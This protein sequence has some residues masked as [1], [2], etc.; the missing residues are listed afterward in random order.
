MEN[1][2]AVVG[3]A[4]DALVSAVEVVIRVLT[5]LLVIIVTVNVFARYV[6]QIGLIWA[7]VVTILLFV[8]VV[9]LGSYAA[10]RR[11]AHL[12]ITFVIDRLPHK[13]QKVASAIAT[14]LVSIFL[15]V[16]VWS[17]FDLVKQTFT[18]GRV[19]SMLGISAAWGY[20]AVPVS[21]IL[22][23][24]ETARVVFSGSF[25]LQQQDYVEEQ[26]TE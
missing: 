12:A 15:F 10:Y 13:S 5:G 4:Y 22:F 11:K 3:Q 20:L 14:L 2:R 24:I 1:V 9:F 17:G 19:T 18:F 23:I 21:G 16:M 26:D 6:L 7:E 8:W 25:L